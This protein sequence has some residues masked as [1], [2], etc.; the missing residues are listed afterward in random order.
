MPL[1]CLHYAAGSIDSSPS[2]FA[3]STS[4]LARDNL[5]APASCILLSAWVTDTRVRPVAAAMD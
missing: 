4:M 2:I 1:Q 5:M 3:S